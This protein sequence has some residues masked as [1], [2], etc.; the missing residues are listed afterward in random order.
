MALFVYPAERIKI[1]PQGDF[2]MRLLSSVNSCLL[3]LR[4]HEAPQE[5]NYLNLILDNMENVA[6][7]FYM[8]Q[9]FLIYLFLMC[10]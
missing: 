6:I 2:R 10:H 8:F 5:M 1:A 7:R 3:T 4:K 9:E